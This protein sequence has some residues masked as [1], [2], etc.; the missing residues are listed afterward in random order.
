MKVYLIRHADAVR[1]DREGVTDVERYLTAIG[2]E[3]MGRVTGKLAGMKVA[4]DGMLTSPFVRA[5]QTAEIV[6]LA[7]GFK[8]AVEVCQ[9][10]ASGRWTRPSI[11]QAL[12][13]RSPAGSYA[14]VGHNPDVEQMVSAL[15]SGIVVSFEKGTVCRIEV[16]G[17]PFRDAGRFEWALQPKDLSVVRTP[18]DAK[19]R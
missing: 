3:E 18:A 14:L 16:D 13:D 5:V 12:E 7:T 6:A 4:F 1:G 11:A 10:L 9:A 2:R 15:A 17:T 8:G 19:G